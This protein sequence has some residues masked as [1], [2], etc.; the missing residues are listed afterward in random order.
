MNE[1]MSVD[2]IAMTTVTTT[3]AGH[4]GEGPPLPT[5]AEDHT[6]QGHALA[7]TPLVI[8]E[9]KFDSSRHP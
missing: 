2:M 6:G 5:M 1:A 9:V 8:T 3:T 4:T 7:P